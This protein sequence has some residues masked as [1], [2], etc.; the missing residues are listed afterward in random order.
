MLADWQR[1]RQ[2]TSDRL[3]RA[4]YSNVGLVCDCG[5]DRRARAT[6]TVCDCV[7]PKVTYHL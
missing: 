7:G 2:R 6:Q 3:A 4:T 5:G 1:N